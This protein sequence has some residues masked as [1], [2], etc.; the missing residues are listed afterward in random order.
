MNI[1]NVFRVILAS[2]M[3]CSVAFGKGN[4]HG[5]TNFVFI[6]NWGADSLSLVDLAAGKAFPEIQVGPKPYD[7]KSDPSGRFVYA[8]LSGIDQISIVDIQANLESGRIKVGDSPRDIEITD[9]GK[10]AV[11]ANSGGS[12][13]SVVD[14]PGKKQVY[15]LDLSSVGKKP[16]PYGVGLLD[17]GRRAL[18]T[19]WGND[20]A[21][22]VE[23]GE[24]EG[25]ILK[26][27]DV[28]RLPYTVATTPDNQFGLVTCF[29]SDQIVVI[30]VKRQE[31]LP[32][33]AV[34]LSPWGLAIT[35]DGAGAVVAN[36]Q[37]RDISCLR[38]NKVRS[39]DLGARAEMIKEVGRVAMR[40][41]LGATGPDIL[42]GRSKN[43]AISSDSR[44]AVVTD[45]AN[46][47]I[48]AL[49]IGSRQILKSIKVGKAPYGVAF[50]PRG[51]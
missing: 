29:S 42:A 35:P 8:T 13:I 2:T 4:V 30:D 28:G 19:C 47:Q 41:P 12:T 44:L 31:T 36:F 48:V 15:T 32:P 20:K 43:V 49:D 6:T 37:S 21:V 39:D 50:V 10:R 17:D 23:L 26:V 45:L 5:G 51:E 9:D 3:L 46:N 1:F 18:I 38:I 25:K 27:F 7:I 40:D 11:V 24:T 34:G 22:L 33:V 16:I 14:I